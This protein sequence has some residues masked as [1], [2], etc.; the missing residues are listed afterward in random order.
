MVN[1]YR[2]LRYGSDGLSWT[3]RVNWILGLN[4]GK[5]GRNGSNGGLRWGKY[6]SM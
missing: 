1:V 4:S 3:G 5:D 6:G 2:G